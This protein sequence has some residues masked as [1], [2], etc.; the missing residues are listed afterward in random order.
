MSKEPESEVWTENPKL[1]VVDDDLFFI[2]Q[3]EHLSGAD[4][5]VISSL[6]TTSVTEAMLSNL[7]TLILDLNL[8]G[9]DVIGFMQSLGTHRHRIRLILM[10]GLP[11]KTI[12]AAAAVARQLR[13]LSVHIASKPLCASSLSLLLSSCSPADQ[14]GEQQREIPQLI[15]SLELNVEPHRALANNELQ[16]YFQPKVDV[17]TGRCVGAEALCRWNHP[18]LGILGPAV[19]INHLE[20]GHLC[21]AFTLYM[22]DDAI[23]RFQSTVRDTGFEGSL[24]INV[25]V[26]ALEEPRLTDHLMSIMRKHQLSPD[27]LIVEITETCVTNDVLSEMA[28]IARMRICGIK[29]SLDDFG[30]GYS[31]LKRLKDIPVDEIKI[32]IKFISDIT[33]SATSKA[34]FFAIMDIAASLNLN[35]VAEGIET[36]DVADWLSA[37][38]NIIGQGY[39]YSRPMGMTQ[40]KEYILT[41]HETAARANSLFN[42]SLPPTS[43]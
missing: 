4:F 11:P 32:D 14:P 26:S 8:P 9:G 27:K 31:S 13:F 5:R 19:F 29:I 20:N 17:H 34:L 25:S 43:H 41:Q 12:E 23:Q 18:T 39:L 7:H 35:V 38:G 6:S 10:S 21:M 15:S 37:H 30:T 3:I 1:L 22:A 33:S 24:S 2:R 36:E 40:F 28:T 16:T 42:L